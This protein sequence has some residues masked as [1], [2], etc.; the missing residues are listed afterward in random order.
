MQPTRVDGTVTPP[1]IAAW[2]IAL[3][4]ACGAAHGGAIQN[5]GNGVL[6]F[7]E[8][9]DDNNAVDG[10]GC[11]SQCRV[12]ALCRASDRPAA[13]A[14]SSDPATGRCYARYAAMGT[15]DPAA[16]A[17]ADEQG[18]LV[19]ITG[20]TEQERVSALVGAGTAYWIGATD[21]VNDMDAV[22]DWVTGE[23]WGFAAFA[24]GEPDD[25][26]LITGSGECLAATTAG[27]I[28]TDCAFDGFVGG[29]ICEFQAR[30]FADG[31][32]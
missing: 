31:F 25:D 13:E 29:R 23:T 10:D 28:D 27:W 22:F 6:D 1:A 21:D 9:C 7:G 20:S 12:G 30:I 18:H 16:T 17:C 11:T 19:T 8:E 4:L 15:F 26:V 24:P 3:M 32:E 5:C 14:L 2:I